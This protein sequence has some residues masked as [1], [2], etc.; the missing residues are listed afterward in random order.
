LFL[1]LVGLL[2]ATIVEAFFVPSASMNPTL[3]S[4]DYILVPKFTYGL[5]VPFVNSTLLS[6]SSPARGDIV[7]FNRTDEPGTIEDESQESLV[8]RVIGLPGD[9]I[10]VAGTQVFV[11]GLPLRE[12][13]ARWAFGG[14]HL[15][16]G[17]VRVPEGRVFLL[18]DNRDESRD[19]RFWHDPFVDIPHIQGKAL[20][21]Y[22]SSFDYHR[23]GTLIN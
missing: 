23:A 14:S 4:Q 18:G 3:H 9:E 20:V 13:Y 5:R 15:P 11:N 19:S 16:Y 12:P 2:K 10:Y 22:W 17:P 21:I 1:A 6:W 8:K 7:V